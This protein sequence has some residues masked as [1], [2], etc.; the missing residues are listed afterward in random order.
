[1]F[2]PYPVADPETG[3]LLQLEV[4]TRP[5]GSRPATYLQ[6]TFKDLPIPVTGVFEVS[7]N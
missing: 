7:H 5:S 4:H 6:L 3:K 2:K 1:M